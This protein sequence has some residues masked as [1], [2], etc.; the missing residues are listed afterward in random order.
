MKIYLYHAYEPCLIGVS[1]GLT[2]QV[3]T[4]T[5]FVYLLSMFIFMV[6]LIVTRKAQLILLK[7]VM[8][9]AMGVLALAGIVVKSLV[10]ITIDGKPIISFDTLT[11]TQAKFWGF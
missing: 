6:P 8:S 5:S 2:I 1:L 10:M 4:F 7:L 9:I 11:P 3:V